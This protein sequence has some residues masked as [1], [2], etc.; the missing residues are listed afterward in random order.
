MSQQRT[1]RQQARPIENR[2]AATRVALIGAGGMA[3]H[4]LRLILQQP[5]RTRVVALCEPSVAAYDAAAAIFV[6]HGV[7]APPQI[8]NVDTLLERRE[9]LGLESAFIITPHVYHH[10]QAVACL[11]AGIDVLLEKP[12]VMN[13]A[14]ARDL[15]RVRDRTGGLL[16]VA[17]NGSL[18]PAVRHAE[19]MLRTGELGALLTISATVWQSWKQATTGTWRQEPAMS[20]GGYMFDTGAHMLNT[21]ADL[22]GEDFT[23]VTARLDSRGTPVDILGVVMARLASGALVTLHGC[24]EGAPTLGSDVRV[25]CSKGV[26]RTGVWGEFLEVQRPGNDRL[27][28]VRVA[29]S[30]G[31]WDQFLRVRAGTIGN[32]S[33]PEVG[34]R[35]ALLWDAI[36]ESARQG[37]QVVC[38]ERA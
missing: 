36:Q 23:E 2:I 8:A 34:L 18:S 35:M 20:G 12:M 22:A 33:P 15:I 24:G 6:E 21:V 32:P 11:E 16:V 31:A 4:H 13:A 10:D 1:V 17:F 14:E 9:E 38:V 26:L 30:L 5:K 25:F 37:G 7:E 29:R 19:R 27:R 28:R 3:R